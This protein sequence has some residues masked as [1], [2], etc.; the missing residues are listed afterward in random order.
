MRTTNLSPR[1]LGLVALL[2]INVA[3]GSDAGSHDSAARAG[4]A[5]DGANGGSQDGGRAGHHSGGTG[6]G[7]AG[8]AQGGDSGNSGAGGSPGGTGG[9]AGR[10]GQ[11]PFDGSELQLND[12]SIL[13]PLPKTAEESENGL[14]TAS[15]SGERGVLLSEATYDSVGHIRGFHNTNPPGAA[16]GQPD[17]PYGDLRVVAARLDPCFAE[18]HPEAPSAVCQNQLRLILQ[19]PAPLDQEYEKFPA[20][21][22]LHLFYSLTR[23]ELLSLVSTIADLRRAQA[24]GQQLGKLQPHPLMV[25]QGLMGA[26]ATGVRAAILAHAGEKNL[27]RATRLSAIGDGPF[28]EFGGFD[29]A[30]GKL[31]AMTIPTLADTVHKQNFNEGFGQPITA[32]TVSPASG[33]ANDF[34]GLLTASANT[35]EPTKVALLSKL[36]RVENP[37]RETPN[38]IDC[39]TCHL[40]T[41]VSQLV[42][43]GALHWA[44]TEVDGAFVPDQRFKAEDLA[45]TFE[46]QSP[47]TNFHAFSYGVSGVGINQRVVNE[48]A[49]IVVYLA[50]QAAR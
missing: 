28:W 47:L 31:T 45:P 32:G 36:R 9:S 8:T 1:F 6:G 30:G 21:G 33:S 46:S 18:T 38:T 39:V 24:P 7:V 26:M 37:A 11:A 27:T 35:D 22:A 49:A 29:I 2:T 41:P 4:S 13:F 43:E 34:S 48:S 14:L 12:V 10:G 44:A 20:D 5:G 3:C 17:A 50:S 23:D 19:Q 25:K 40:A 42:V 16:G 15:A